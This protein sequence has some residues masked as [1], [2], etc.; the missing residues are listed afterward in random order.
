MECQQI[1]REYFD[2]DIPV[3]ITE[4][5]ER[6]GQ[7]LGWKGIIFSPTP[8]KCWV[9]FNDGAIFDFPWECV[10]VQA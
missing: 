2:V 3:T 8:E 6:L 9:K 4:V 7:F 10:T 5:P 1:S